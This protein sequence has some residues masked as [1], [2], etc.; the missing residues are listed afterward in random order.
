MA[1]IKCKGL[2]GVVFDVTVTFASTTMNGLTALIR[3][4]E[5]APIATSMYGEVRAEKKKTINQATDGAKTLAAAG[6]VQG[7]LVVCVPLKT[8]NKE[9]RS[10]QKG[11]IAQAKREGLA[12]GT[13]SVVYYRALSTWNKNRLPNPYEG[14][15]YNV[16]DDEN[17]GTLAASRPWT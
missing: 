17:T 14:N 4:I 1:T 12:A 16:D 13:D 8:G 2:T 9:A 7:D 11:A 3:A 6:L 15:A 5:G 10:D